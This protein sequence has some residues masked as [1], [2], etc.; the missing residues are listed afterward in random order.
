ME[1]AGGTRGGSQAEVIVTHYEIAELNRQ[2][3]VLRDEIK[4]LSDKQER[5][6]EHLSLRIDGAKCKCGSSCSK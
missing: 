1:E 5:E 2:F 4:R 3:N 6:F